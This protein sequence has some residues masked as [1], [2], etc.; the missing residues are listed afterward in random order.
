M[1][2]ASD[3][4]R[5]D[6]EFPNAAQWR[7]LVVVMPAYN[8]AT[9]L[10]L[11]YRDIPT[12]LADEVIVVDD[13][14]RDDTVHVAR[15]LGLRVLVHPENRGYGA[16]QKTCYAEAL[17]LGARTVVMLHPD[18][19][20]D[21]RGLPELL[22]PIAA[23]EKDF[24]IG[25]RLADGKAVERGMPRYKW[26]GNRLLTVCENAAL[27]L[28]F[29]ELHS[30]LRA[31][32]RQLLET[33]P[34]RLNSDDF[35]FDTQMIAQATHFGFRMGEVPCPARYMPEASSIGFAKSVKYGLATLWTMLQYRLHRCG[36]VRSPLF[37]PDP[38]ARPD[39]A[40]VGEKAGE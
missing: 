6:R 40:K 9:T 33:V 7:P 28:R 37:M 19:Q 29:T 26:L 10:E 3:T 17:R 35:V 13:A 34:W 14:S 18:Y 21:P 36:V 27:G 15:A 2:E 4:T 32:T 11:T 8:A 31:Y 38:A 30:G 23:G 20:Y 24:M 12:G 25:S 39:D 16:N 22:R 1:T 5:W